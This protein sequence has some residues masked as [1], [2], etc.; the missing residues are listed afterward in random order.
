MTIR[1]SDYCTQREEFNFSFIL[2]TFIGTLGFSIVLPLLVFLVID[3]DGNAIV[4]GILVQCTL[5]FNS[6]VLQS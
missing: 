6:L 5:H 4:Y 2:I 1:N 3:L